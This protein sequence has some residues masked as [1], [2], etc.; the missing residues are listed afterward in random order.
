MDNKFGKEISNSQADIKKSMEDSLDL[1]ALREKIVAACKKSDQDNPNNWIT[2][3]DQSLAKLVHET[4]ADNE[5]RNIM[6]CTMDVPKTITEILEICKIPKTSGY[7]VVNSM[8]EDKLLNLVD[9]T[10][11]GDRTYLKYRSEIQK[12]Q[13]ETTRNQSTVRIK[14]VKD[15]R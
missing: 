7:R 15:K 4:F 6:Y 14:F 11:I 8:I 2:L 1:K 10:K 13:V 9:K 5:K 12:V 3:E